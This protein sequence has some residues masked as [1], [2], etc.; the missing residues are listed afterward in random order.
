MVIRF[1]SLV[2]VLG[3]IEI[4]RYIRKHY[5]SIID[6]EFLENEE[7]EFS[8]EIDLLQ[9][10][11]YMILRSIEKFPEDCHLKAKAFSETIEGTDQ[12]QS[13]QH[14]STSNLFY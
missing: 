2:I 4:H 11:S 5:V 8:R 1:I 7:I 12:S 9:L 10:R 14:Q 13:R 3:L 6:E